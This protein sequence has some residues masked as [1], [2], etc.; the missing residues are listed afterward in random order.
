MHKDFLAG[1]LKAGLVAGLF[2]IVNLLLY[3]FTALGAHYAGFVYSLP[4]LYVL[5]YGFSLIIL[6]SLQMVQKNSAS[7]IGYVFLGL[8]TLK[9]V[10]AYFVAR[11][12]ISKTIDASAEKINF[13][14]VF[15]LFLL[16]EVYFT[17]KLLNKKQ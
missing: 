8:T 11:P 15:V 13:F 10:G 6:F 16:I 1:A 12:I 5:Y 3:H 9:A 4:V 14:L 7:Q 2:L 17:A